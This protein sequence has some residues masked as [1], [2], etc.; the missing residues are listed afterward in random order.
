MSKKGIPRKGLKRAAIKSMKGGKSLKR[1]KRDTTGMSRSTKAGTK[2]SVGKVADFMKRGKYS[3]RTGAQAAVFLTG[4]IEYIC[5][6]I[7]ELSGNMARTMEKKRIPP[8]AIKLALD[9][10]D[11]F[12]FI[13]THI[14]IAGAG[15]STVTQFRD[16]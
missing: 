2:F 1:R 12:P 15:T 8:R 14:T 16:S 9:N 7:L 3:D 11:E 6:E 10:D 13:T 5:A 4:A